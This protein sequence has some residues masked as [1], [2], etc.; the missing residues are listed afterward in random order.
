[1]RDD[2]LRELAAMAERGDLRGALALLN[3]NA[4]SRARFTGMYRIE[5]DMIFGIETFDR[6]HPHDAVPVAAPAMTSYCLG[7]YRDDEPWAVTEALADERLATHP[8]RETWRSYVGVPLRDTQGHLVG[9][10]CHYD[11]C[12]S[13]MTPADV[14]M[15][16]AAAPMLA[17]FADRMRR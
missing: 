15:L 11:Y 13:P 12:P 17:R 5:R 16:R 1:M 2:V 3:A 4:H 14:G 10:I 7:V 6:E 9:T 8:S